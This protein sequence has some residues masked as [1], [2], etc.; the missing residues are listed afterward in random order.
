MTNPT[1]ASSNRSRWRPALALGGAFVLGLL[2]GGLLVGTLVY[3]RVGD[4][5][6][7]RTQTGFVERMMETIEPTGPDQRQTIRPI[8]SATGQTVERTLTHSRD[9]LRTELQ[10]MRKALA[11]HLTPEQ[12]DRLKAFFDRLHSRARAPVSSPAQDTTASLSPADSTSP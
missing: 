9:S 1:P 7:L 4:L 12:M 8:L 11:P 5:A 3:H 2:V 6:R 10:R